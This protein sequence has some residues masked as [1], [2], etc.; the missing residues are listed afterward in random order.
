MKEKKIYVFT[1]WGL[2]KA[3]IVKERI[4]KNTGVPQYKVNID[5]NRENKNKDY[6]F[7]YTENEF[8]KFYVTALV[9][10]LFKPFGWWIKSVFKGK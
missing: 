3:R 5:I 9:F 7:W 1:S 6:G 4:D 2:C 10:E 8:H